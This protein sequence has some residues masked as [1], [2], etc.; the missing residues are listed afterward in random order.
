[1]RA[2][3]VL[4]ALLMFVA[5]TAG[6]FGGSGGGDGGAPQTQFLDPNRGPP[7]PPGTYKFDGTSQVVTPGPHA[8][9]PIEKVYLASD[10]DG[11]DIEVGFWRPDVPDGTVTPVIVDAGPYYGNNG[12]PMQSQ[13]GHIGRLVEN[14]VPHG[15]TVAAIA[16]RG[17]GGSGGCMDLMG[18]L[19]IADLDQA[20]TWLGE[21]TWSNGNVGMIGK[22]YDGSTPWQVA[23]TGNPHL[24]TIVPISGVPDLYELMYRN[25]TSEIRGPIVL[26]GLYYS[27]A[28]RE[29]N[30]VPQNE[31]EI[32]R[33]AMHTLEALACP[34][35]V[36]GLAASLYSGF[37]GE[38]DPFGYWAERNLK[39][40]VAANYK[41]SVYLVQGLQDWNVDPGLS[42]PF[43]QRLNDSGLFV[44]QMLGQWGHDYPDFGHN[45]DD[46]P[47]MRFDWAEILLNW[48]DYWLKDNT[49][50][51]LGPAVQVLD[52]SGRW[53]ID[54]SFPPNDAKWL[55]FNLSAGGALTPDEASAGSAMLLPQPLN[56]DEANLPLSPPKEAI[57]RADFLTEPVTADLLISGLP[58]IPITVT[59]QG[60]G[61]HV[62][63]WL[64]TVAP[65]GGETRIG[66][67]MIN[68]RFADGTEDPKEV[69]PQQPLHVA[70][71]IQPMDAVVHE[72]ERL[73]LRVWQHRD[74]PGADSAQ[75]RLPVLPPQPVRLD[76]GD[77]SGSQLRLP[78]IERGPEAYFEPPRP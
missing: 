61:G 40:A 69:S 63:A 46:D 31:E 30:E 25:G 78:V 51:A 45:G 26:N 8:I 15:Y 7:V 39:P 52:A 68:L 56:G 76:F 11:L 70:M 27:F 57:N 13:S 34:D 77:N 36:P 65:D 47:N 74:N 16:I 53:H 2:R 54:D 73:L 20:I 44:H 66:W 50:V 4:L 29:G 28:V 49:T 64:Y 60:N 23:T 19:E 5:V 75:G 41:G 35:H 18:P 48:F 62:A 59:P 71:E 1:M 43:A 17:T 42:I 10:L 32:E 12:P 9:L 21:Q 37:R 3:P 24:K 58:Q 72:G 38:R 6:C 14:F 67:T 55:T 33:T 22:S